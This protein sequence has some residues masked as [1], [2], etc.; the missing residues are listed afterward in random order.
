[1]LLIQH[2]VW[3]GLLDLCYVPNHSKRKR[4]NEHLDRHVAQTDSEI[5]TQES[6][7]QLELLATQNTSNCGFYCTPR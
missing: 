2:P 1:M 7:N 6:Y 3:K 5:K 4:S